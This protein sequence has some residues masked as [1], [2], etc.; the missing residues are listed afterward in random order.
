MIL[1]SE[2]IKWLML[3]AVIVLHVLISSGRNSFIQVD[4][5][6]IK[7]IKII[8]IHTIEY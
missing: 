3:I 5:F 2:F 1:R 6:E 8:R 4:I 7:T